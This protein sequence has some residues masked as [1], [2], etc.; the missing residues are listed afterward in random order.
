MVTDAHAARVVPITVAVATRDR[1]AALRRCLAAL[2]AGE[3]LPAEVLIVDQSRREDLREVLSAMAR[4]S[5]IQMR[6][7]RQDADGLARSRNAAFSEATHDLVAVTDDDCV[8]EPG[9][10]GAI[11]GAFAIDPPPDV[12]TG[13]VLPL[14][15]AEPGTFA[16]STRA[17]TERCD[18]VGTHAPWLV[19][20]GAN[21]CARR[22]VVAALQGY[23]ERLGVGAGGGAG[24]DIE[25]L[26]RLLRAGCRIRYEPD[27]LIRHERKP[28]S[29]RMATRVSYGR[30]IGA[31][32]G[33]MLG[34][35]DVHG[36][37]V[38]ARWVRLR[39]AMAV[40]AARRRDLHGIRE[41]LV[42]MRG[43]I[44]GLAYGWTRRSTPRRTSNA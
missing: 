34:A 21:F 27:A 33:L 10:V 39:A 32:C 15:P 2:L 4:P 19:G 36:V 30:G 5:G 12:V 29:S 14:G 42:V 43:T 44:G 16:T 9:W 35:A 22:S 1:S 20:T 3:T 23:D 25:L 37:A 7:L 28:L 6:H 17:T 40:R 26:D 38:L 24:E 41:E 18:Y 31:M 13:R 8:P 11:A